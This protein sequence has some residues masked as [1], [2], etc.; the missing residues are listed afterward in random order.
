MLSSTL[1]GAD[2]PPMSVRIQPG[3]PKTRTFA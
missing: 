2:E 3:A 1:Y